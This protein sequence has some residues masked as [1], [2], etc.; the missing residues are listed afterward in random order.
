MRAFT[1]R[2][3]WIRQVVVTAAAAG[4][5]WTAGDRLVASG[6]LVAAITAALTVRVSVHKSVR[7]G[8]GQILGTG[9]GALVALSSVSAFGV[10]PI[11]VVITVGAGLVAARALR[12]GQVA[13]LNVP[14]TALIVIGPGLAESTAEYRTLSVMIG[15][16]IAIGFSYFTHPLDPAGRTVDQI[17]KLATEAAELLGTMA[18]GV[19]DGIDK[20]ETARWLGAAR[21]LVAK[22]PALRDQAMEAKQYARWYP[23]AAQEEA[24][25]LY[26]RAVALDHA[27]EQVRTIARTLFDAAVEGGL[28]DSINQQI[29]DALS[30]ASYA[31]SATVVELQDADEM[32]LVELQHLH[33]AHDFEH[34]LHVLR[35][36]RRHAV[37]P[38]RIRVGV[39]WQDHDGP[40]A[41][42]TL[43][44]HAWQA[45]GGGP[46]VDG[47]RGEDAAA[48]A[49]GV[50]RYLEQVGAAGDTVTGSGLAKPA[51][52][53]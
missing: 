32:P 21:E 40:G 1:S 45:P 19:T 38:M 29:S 6:G 16:L 27:V 8:F 34:P 26:T 23:L 5:A 35:R 48:L 50:D 13:T 10:G 25:A 30:A 41:G 43:H 51:D 3:E 4:V 49:R 44:R 53:A 24:D 17:S 18:E 33:P 28:P 11:T 42:V 46:V 22:V 20:E 37:H 7:E 2:A 31:V 12:L 36:R 15:A 47:G 14:V 9:I 39:A 52:S